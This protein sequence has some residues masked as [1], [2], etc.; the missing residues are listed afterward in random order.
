MQF[1]PDWGE[2]GMRLVEPL[3]GAGEL[4]CLGRDDLAPGPNDVLLAV[5]VDCPIFVH[6]RARRKG[7]RGNFVL[8][9]VEDLGGPRF[10]LWPGACGRPAAVGWSG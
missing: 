7:T 8:D 9:V 10:T 6:R 4:W 2:S 5:V 3:Y 1:R